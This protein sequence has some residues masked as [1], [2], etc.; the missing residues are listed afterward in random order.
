MPWKELT[1]MSQRREFGQRA[2]QNDTSFSELCREYG[3]SRWCGYKWYSRYLNGEDLADRSRRPHGCPHQTRPEIEEAVLAARREF[4]AWGG[5]KIHKV[6]LGR[7]Y[8]Y[9]PS[10]STITQILKRNGL[11]DPEEAQKHRPFQSFEMDEPNQLWQMDFKGY[12]PL[13]DGTIC[14]PLTVLDDC[15]R[16]LLEIAACLDETRETVQDRLTRVFKENGLPER[17]LMDNGPPWGY[18]EERFTGLAAWL[19]RLGITVCH[20]RPYHP[21]TQGKEE[22]LHRTLDDEVLRWGLPDDSA[23]CQ[24][25]FSEWRGV[26]NWIRPH[27]SLGMRTPA[28]RYCK[29]SKPFP[30]TLP[31]IVY[32]SGYIVRKVNDLG[33]ISLQNRHY[34]VGRAFWRF[35]VGLRP[36]DTDGVYDVF[37][38]HQ[39]IRTISLRDEAPS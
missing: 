37:F 24:R 1:A 11:I 20:G 17:M 35:P 30:E 3:I 9:V 10:P 36:T 25:A 34:R 15:S 26:Y 32:D 5:R 4:P 27:E 2:S 14:H 21:Q 28:S 22:R 16:Y 13:G 6:L 29:S 39:K 8:Q 12:F 23:D 38:C 31:P 18:G 7:D 19:I 33:R